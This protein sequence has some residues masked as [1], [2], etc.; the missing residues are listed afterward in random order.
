MV[1]KRRKTTLNERI[2][3]IACLIL[4]ASSV[5]WIG[6]SRM[7]VSPVPVTDLARLDSIAYDTETRRD[8][9][10]DSVAL[11]AKKK[12]KPAVKKNKSRRKSDSVKV[13][14]RDMSRDYF[15]PEEQVN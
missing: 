10:S 2:G 6:I 13:T 7:N 1:I 12:R 4:I 14:R 9:L 11:L 5:I 15:A 3:I 8:A